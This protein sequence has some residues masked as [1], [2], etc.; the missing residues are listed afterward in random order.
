MRRMLVALQRKG[1]RAFSTEKTTAKLVIGDELACWDLRQK[2]ATGGN[3]V[4]RAGHGGWGQACGQGPDRKRPGTAMAQL[5]MYARSS[6]TML[7]HFKQGVKVISFTL[8]K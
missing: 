8:F 2:N 4:N 3:M 5:S 6:G 7:E 1:K